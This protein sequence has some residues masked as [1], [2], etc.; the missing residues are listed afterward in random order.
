MLV[1]ELYSGECYEVLARL[2]FGRLACAR[3]NQSYIVPIY[4]AYEAHVLY[5]FATMGNK[6]DWMRSNP[7]VAVEADEVKSH[8][9]WTIVVVQGH[10]EE[11]PRSRSSPSRDGRHNQCSRRDRSGGRREPR[12]PRPAVASTNICP[13]IIVFT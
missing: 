11:F 10:Y 7:L 3:K 2:G 5:G 12:R 13:L 6:I 4:F 9:E 1:S 8:I